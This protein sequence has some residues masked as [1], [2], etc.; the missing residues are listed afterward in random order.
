MKLN[1]RELRTLIESLLSESI[2]D[3]S[4]KEVDIIIVPSYNGRPATRTYTV[5]A[6]EGPLIVDTFEAGSRILVFFYDDAKDDFEE[7]PRIKTRK[8]GDATSI[9]WPGGRHKIEVR[10]TR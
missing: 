5:E 3:A 10:S 6:P 4:G 1:R 9:H 7:E 8:I 2:K